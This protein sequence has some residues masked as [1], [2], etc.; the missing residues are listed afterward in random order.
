LP[1]QR[2]FQHLMMTSS[3]LTGDMKFRNM[4][5]ADVWQS[6]KGVGVGAGLIVCNLQR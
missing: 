6:Y 2:S 5:H 1:W 3:H 4:A